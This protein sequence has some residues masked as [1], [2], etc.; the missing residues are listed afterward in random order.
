MASGQDGGIGRHTAPP[1]TTKRRTTTNIKIKNTNQDGGIGRHI[2]PPHTTK[3]RITTNLK[4]KN[5]QNRQKI[6]L[7]GSLTTRELKEKHSSRLVGG[8]ETGSWVERTR[9][10]AVAGE[11]GKAVACRLG[12]STFACR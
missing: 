12:S 7:Y 3:R 6:E 8:A 1:R 4:T 5:N 10:K 2:V 11:L 9:G